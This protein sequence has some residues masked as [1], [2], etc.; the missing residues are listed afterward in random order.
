MTFLSLLA[1]L[2]PKTAQYA[3][4]LL[5][6]NCMLSVYGQ[7]DVYKNPHVFFFKVTVIPPP[8]QFVLVNPWW[9]YSSTCARLILPFVEQHDILVSS[10]LQ[11]V[12]VP[13]NDIR[14]A[15][16]VSQSS[17][18]LLV[19]DLLNIHSALSSSSLKKMLNSIE[20]SI[21][22]WVTWQENRLDFVPLATTP[23]IRYFSLL[24]IHYTFK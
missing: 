9:D 20:T 24:Y 11:H 5:C 13:L 2:F 15:W 8:L 1:I 18:F 6:C 14:T 21:N 17:K 23:S 4:V 7:S 19:W 3:V 10:F 12:W 16:W 22:P